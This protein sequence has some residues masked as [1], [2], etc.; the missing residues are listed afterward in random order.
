[1]RRLERCALGAMWSMRYEVELLLEGCEGV[2]ALRRAR[3]EVSVLVALG[4]RLVADDPRPPALR[5]FSAALA[6]A[7]RTWDAAF[8]DVARRVLVELPCGR[9]PCPS[10]L[11]PQAGR[12]DAHGT[13]VPCPRCGEE[14]RAHRYSCFGHAEGTVV[15][16]CPICGPLACQ[17]EQGPRLHIEAPHA[18]RR[19][20]IIDVTLR[21]DAADPAPDTGAARVLVQH[22]DMTVPGSGRTWTAARWQPGRRFAH[23]LPPDAGQD[24][25]DL[26]A[27]WVRHM[28]VAFARLPARLA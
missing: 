2:A 21:I 11:T 18:W 19:D 15:Q 28:E 13:G 10:F 24:R 27:L 25:H 3:D 22:R 7:V 16:E 9:L 17:R 8:M 12:R 5:A 6:K 20:R 23:R 14:V 4:A 26:R 1:M